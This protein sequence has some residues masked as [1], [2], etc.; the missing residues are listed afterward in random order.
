M[1]DRSFLRT[2]MER[3]SMSLILAIFVGVVGEKGFHSLDFGISKYQ[4]RISLSQLEPRAHHLRHVDSEWFR[5]RKCCYH[6]S[7]SSPHWE[8]NIMCWC[9][10]LC[11][12]V[13]E[14]RPAVR[15]TYFVARWLHV[16][17]LQIDPKRSEF[18]NVKFQVDSEWAIPIWAAKAQK[19]VPLRGYNAS[20][21]GLLDWLNP[22]AV[23]ARSKMHNRMTKNVAGWSRHTQHANSI[24]SHHLTSPMPNRLENANFCPL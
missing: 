6:S 8:G 13:L 16:E 9:P 22:E 21:S 23:I 24:I 2:E 4:H 10:G 3:A 5:A 12:G 15:A 19:A 1:R 18:S 14:L 20:K 17:L 11:T 7:H